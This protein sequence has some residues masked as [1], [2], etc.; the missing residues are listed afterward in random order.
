MTAGAR[1]VLPAAALVAG[2]VL[3]FAFRLDRYLSF[4]A[5]RA[6]RAAL[7][8]F[9]ADNHGLAAAAYMAVY[10]G[11]VALS[12][13]GGAVMTLAGGF[14]FGAVQATLYVVVAATAGATIVFL[15][16]RFA[17]REVMQRRA[18]TF[19]QRMEQGFRDNALSYLL[20]LR[21]VPAFPFWAVNLAPALLGVNLST[22]VLATALGIVP[23]TFVFASFG[24]GLGALF[25]A[26]GEIS[27]AGIL[28]PQIVAGLVGLAILAL[29]PVA[30]RKYKARGR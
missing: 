7:Q 4:E 20:V 10:A 23:G 19:V 8:R 28:S 18:G 17:L 29:I 13:P 2:L 27:L 15:I 30:I 22:Y 26:G 6:N 12:V 11:V 1:R 16:A 14:L 3:F 9:V 25:D 21:L 24:A 5:L